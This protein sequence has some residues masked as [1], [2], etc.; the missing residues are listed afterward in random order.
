MARYPDESTWNFTTGAR[1]LYHQLRHGGMDDITAGNSVVE[2]FRKS[3]GNPWVGGTPSGR[4]SQPVAA[5]VSP[6][7]SPYSPGYTGE[8]DQPITIPAYP[9]TDNVGVMAQ[10]ETFNTPDGPV[11]V[12]FA[13]PG[14]SAPTPQA[15][16]SAVIAMIAA[17]PQIMDAIKAAFRLIIRRPGRKAKEMNDIAIACLLQELPK[18]YRKALCQYE[19]GL[20]APIALGK[21]AQNAFL[22]LVLADAINI[23]PSYDITEHLIEELIGHVATA[24]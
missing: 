4:P 9:P 23:N 13:G 7:A 19:G 17:Y 3:G 12:T 5:P 1:A 22:L 2:T 11:T 20:D 18:S 21:E 6:W 16:L 15:A 14:G 8:P 10:G 24:H